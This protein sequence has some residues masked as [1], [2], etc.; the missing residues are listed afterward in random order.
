MKDFKDP[1]HDLVVEIVDDFTSLYR[2]DDFKSASL[3]LVFVT[4]ND[5]VIKL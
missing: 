1:K 4:Q 3:P 5:E 2:F